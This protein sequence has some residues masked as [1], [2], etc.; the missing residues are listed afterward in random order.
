MFVKDGFHV[1]VVSGGHAVYDLYIGSTHPSQD[2]SQGTSGTCTPFT[3]VYYH[4][5]Y[6]GTPGDSWGL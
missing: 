2:A 6:W 1:H 5:I 4:G 3:Y